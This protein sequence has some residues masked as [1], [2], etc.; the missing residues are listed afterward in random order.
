M[1]KKQLTYEFL[2]EEYVVKGRST[3]SISKELGIFPE[4]CRRALKKFK[5]PIR[6]RSKASKNFY[7]KGGQNS[8]KGYKFS[9]EEKKQAAINSK[10]YWLSEDSERAREKISKASKKY[11]KTVSKAEKKEIIAKLHQ[12]CRKASQEGSKAQLTL[13][14]ILAEDYDYFVQTGFVQLAGIGD[15][16]VDIL[17]PNEGIAIEVDGITHFEQIYSDNRY[18]RAQE[19]DKRKNK[20]LI[21]SGWTVL[22]VQLY[23][24]RFSKGSCLITAAE[25]HNLIKDKSFKKNSV[26]FVEMH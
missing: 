16:E 11:W 15:L 23:C 14:T 20:I 5:I 17:L 10:E 26:N 2:Y 24:E 12:A 19:A 22:R 3:V 25:I 8:R 6:S 7:E 21:D 4:Q 18:E 13:A 9:E 1:S